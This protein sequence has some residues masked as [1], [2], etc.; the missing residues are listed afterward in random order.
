MKSYKISILSVILLS[1]FFSQCKE[2]PP[3]V[4]VDPSQIAL[5]D[6]TYVSPT[7]IPMAQKNVLMEE[8]S[9]VKCSNCPKGNAKSKRLP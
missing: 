3:A 2:I 7:A 4:I 6:T 1:V 8:F 9:G 5:F